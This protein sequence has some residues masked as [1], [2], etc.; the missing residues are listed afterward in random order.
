MTLRFLWHP[1][2][3]AVV[4][5]VL[6]TVCVLAILRSRRDKDGQQM[7]WWRRL[8]MV[9]TVVLI[10]AT[11]AV[12]DTSQEVTSN[13]D[14]FIVVDKTGSMS[15]NDYNG[16]ERRLAGVSSDINSLVDAFPDARF[17]IIT[18]D[19]LAYRELPLSS[20]TRAVRAWAD[21]VDVE[22]HY[23]SAGSSIARPAD[24]LE[25][26]LSRAAENS[27]ENIRL[28][29]F[30]SDG[31]NTNGDASSVDD[32]LDAFGNSAQYVDAG[33]VFGYGTPEGATMTI[34]SRFTNVPD[35]FI[36]DPA[37]GE[38]AISRIDEANLQ[39]VAGLLGIEYQHRTA[40]GDL[41]SFADSID[42]ESIMMD[43]RSDVSV[44]RDFYWPLTWVL[45]GLLA[46]EAFALLREIRQMGGLRERAS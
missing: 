28:V 10:G 41:T 39:E 43:G 9:V 22:R 26:Q 19:S 25:N 5:L 35:S 24:I 4:L 33:A 32:S 18:F 13:V 30:M 2:I 45:A 12:V 17:S 7:S 46:W 21:T 3:L 40:P 15:A 20:D 38:P 31:E 27:P 36:L 42:S 37:T 14:I 8:G 1:A 44:Y 16:Q 6:G 11:P 29:I 23:Y 34:V